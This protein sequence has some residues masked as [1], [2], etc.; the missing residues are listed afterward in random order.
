MWF[1]VSEQLEIYFS[2][3]LSCASPIQVVMSKAFIGKVYPM[4]DWLSINWSTL[5]VGSM[6]IESPFVWRE[7]VVL[8]NAIKDQNDVVMIQ[9][10]FSKDFFCKNL[11]I[12][13]AFE[14]ESR[15]E[16]IRRTTFFKHLKQYDMWKVSSPSKVRR[17]L[18]TFGKM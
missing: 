17:L 10:H 6:F 7:A 18:I 15:N 12:I 2:F 5:P 13:K 1:L 8:E 11:S 4:C 14:S 16:N 3:Y 9:S